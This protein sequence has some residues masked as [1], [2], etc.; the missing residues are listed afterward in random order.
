[1]VLNICYK[2]EIFCLKSQDTNIQLIFLIQY[3]L[4]CQMDTDKWDVQNID[5]NISR[6]RKN[7]WSIEKI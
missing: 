6:I 3:I 4:I 2:E 1:M 7:D 5:L